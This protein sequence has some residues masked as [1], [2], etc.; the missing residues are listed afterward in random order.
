MILNQAAKPST[1]RTGRV[2]QL[3]QARTA[4]TIMVSQENQIRVPAVP[5]GKT[6]AWAWSVGTFF[7]IGHLRPGPGTWGSLTAALLWWAVAL[8][9]PAEARVWALGAAI[10]A[11][12]FIGI[13]AATLVARGA[14]RKDPSQVVIDEVVGQWVALLAVPLH[15][16]P[17]LVGF[18]LFRVFDILKPPPV[19]QLERLPEGTGIVVDDLGAG[20]YALIIMQLLLH[21]GILG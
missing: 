11:V 21:F 14:G 16:K 15:W 13:R 1:L 20:V 6:P 7:G 3:A 8:R 19:R 18:I 5:T 12:T 2:L 4:Q 10:V 17:L 9:I